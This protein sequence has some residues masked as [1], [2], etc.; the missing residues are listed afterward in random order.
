MTTIYV[1]HKGDAFRKA[2]RDLLDLG[3]DAGY[4]WVRI[5]YEHPNAGLRASSSW[6]APRPPHMEGGG[7]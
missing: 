2:V 7:K 4:T 1:D 5:E 6:G 3:R